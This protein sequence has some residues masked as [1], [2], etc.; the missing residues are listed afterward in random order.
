ME[1]W[2]RLRNT[3]TSSLLLLAAFPISAENV[4]IALKSNPLVDPEAACVALQI[5]QNLMMD[6]GDGPAEQVTLFPT[7][8][9]VEIVSDKMLP[10]EVLPNGRIKTYPP[11]LDCLTPNGYVPLPEVLRAYWEMGGDIVVCPLCWT[12]R[13]EGETPIYGVVGN[14]GQIHNLFLNADKVIDF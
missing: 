5:G 2:P 14:G 12:T 7:L 3:L 10:A 9:G 13:H 8:D 6:I 1:S 11:H 4:V